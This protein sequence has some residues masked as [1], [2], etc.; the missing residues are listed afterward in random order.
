[1]RSFKPDSQVMK[2]SKA[3]TGKEGLK[4]RLWDKILFCHIKS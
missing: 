3:T 1:M 2:Q 4:K